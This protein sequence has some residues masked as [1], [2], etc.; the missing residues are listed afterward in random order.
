[1]Y[2]NEYKTKNENKNTANKYRYFLESS[3]VGVNRLLNFSL[4]QSNYSSK[5]YIGKRY[6]LPK[7]LLRITPS[8][9]IEKFVITNQ[10]ILIHNDM[11]K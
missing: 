1:M 7:A 8:S 6:Y 10:S 4:F 3:F 9:S 5:I 11:K 2:W